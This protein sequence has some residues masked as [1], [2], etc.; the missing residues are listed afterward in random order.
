MKS[1]VEAVMFKQADDYRT[2]VNHVMSKY[3]HKLNGMEMLEILAGKTG[4]TTFVK[5][6]NNKLKKTNP[7]FG[8][9]C[10]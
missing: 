6:I 2:Y 9:C 7:S 8:A 5:E 3:N 4:N 1:E 10:I